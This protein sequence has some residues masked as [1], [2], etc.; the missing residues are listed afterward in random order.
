MYELS[1]FTSSVTY[2]RFSDSTITGINMNSLLI[3]GL[4]PEDSKNYT[5]IISNNGIKS[6]K[7]ENS[8]KHY[9]IGRYQYYKYNNNKK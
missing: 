3:L 5:C 8:Y 2:C 9:V 1:W 4:E 7:K 6:K